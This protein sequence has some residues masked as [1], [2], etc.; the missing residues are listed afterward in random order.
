MRN[1]QDSDQPLG[2]PQMLAA[3]NELKAERK[4][5]QEC[6]ATAEMLREWREQLAGQFRCPY[7][8]D[9]GYQFVRCSDGARLARPCV[10][11][12][13]PAG[14]RS[15]KPLLTE[16]GWQFDDVRLEWHRAA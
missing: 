16:E 3:W 13:A 4:A 9:H 7:C 6:K 10:C 2:T 5:E 12:K 11:D 14:Q 1:H 15:A 8:R